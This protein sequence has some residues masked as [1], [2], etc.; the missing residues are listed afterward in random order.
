MKIAIVGC[1]WLGLPLAL[2][3]QKSGHSIVATSRSE[4]SCSQLSSL[5]FHSVKFALGATLTHK[6][7]APIFN[8]DLL[9]L[10]IPVGRK[11]SSPEE[12][13]VNM[14][15]LLRLAADSNI[16]QVIFV[17]T[18]S[19]YGDQ[20]TV[21]SEISQTGPNTSSG[22]I[23]L[24]VEQIVQQYFDGQTT[25]LRLAGLVGLDRHPVNYL[26]GKTELAAPNK[27]VNLVHQQDVIQSVESIIKNEIWGR[28]I[29]LCATEHPTRQD[30]YTW[31]AKKLGIA[32]P[33]FIEELGQPGGKLIDASSSL[34]ILGM[35]LKYASPY[36]ML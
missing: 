1:G 17:S 5:G 21:V 6:N 35:H 23:N 29:V 9:V 28:T 22:K 12:F 34:N 26:A 18:T 32:A 14:E 4:A 30:Y 36:D 2:S 20:N 13:S 7:F 16:K 3:L 27:V 19:V 25:I 11:T 24:L 33:K 8:C 31:A 15:D 10:N